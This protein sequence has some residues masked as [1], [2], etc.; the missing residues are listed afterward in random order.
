MIRK[1]IINGKV[2]LIQTTFFVYDNESKHKNGVPRLITSNKKEFN[3]HKKN[4]LNKVI[5]KP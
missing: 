5:L 4:E 3:Y 1:E 2:F